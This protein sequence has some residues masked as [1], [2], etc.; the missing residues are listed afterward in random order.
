MR[1]K[2]PNPEESCGVCPS[3]RTSVHGGSSCN[4]GVLGHGI[5]E[6]TVL[7]GLGELVTVLA[8]RGRFLK[9]PMFEKPLSAARV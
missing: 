9:L 6:N 3:V 8:C 2:L 1:Q 7:L 5:A 4:A